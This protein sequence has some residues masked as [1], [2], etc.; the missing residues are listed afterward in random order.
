[1]ASNVQIT[2]VKRDTAK[3]SPHAAALT[4]F[5]SRFCLRF[6]AAQP[7]STDPKQPTMK[8]NRNLLQITF[9][10]TEPN[11]NMSN[12][13][14]KIVFLHPS[15]NFCLLSSDLA[16]LCLTP[17]VFKD[18]TFLVGSQH[19]KKSNAD[20]LSRKYL[21]IR[22]SSPAPAPTHPDP[23]LEFFF[24]QTDRRKFSCA[25][26]QCKERGQSAA[27]RTP[28]A[29]NMCARCTSSTSAHLSWSASWNPKSM[30][31]HSPLYGCWRHVFVSDIA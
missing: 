20:K 5:V 14:L 2:S 12:M 4:T 31:L 6:S 10:L 24:G 8:K 27:P 29:H 23:K 15:E 1:M 3:P 16:Q 7:A 17:S 18:L 21:E 28:R 30:C 9:G 26:G 11:M 22:V 19:T 25:Q 13:A